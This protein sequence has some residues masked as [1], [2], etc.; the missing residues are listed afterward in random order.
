[1]IMDNTGIEEPTPEEDNIVLPPAPITRSA[2]V[3]ARRDVQELAAREAAF[4]GELAAYGNAA[5]LGGE[6]THSNDDV[7]ING[8][9]FGPPDDDEHP[10]H[11]LGGA[12]DEYEYEEWEYEP[13]APEPPEDSEDS[14]DE[15]DDLPSAAEIQRNLSNLRESH[16]YQLRPRAGGKVVTQAASQSG[17][18]LRARVSGK[19][20]EGRFVP[21]KQETS[22]HITVKKALAT[23]KR[24]AL[25]EIYREI[26]Q[27]DKKGVFHPRH[28]RTLPASS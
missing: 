12:Q 6:Q 7:I 23:H 13:H 21:D 24:K 19:Y 27:M 17:Y 9:N 26:M 2:A 11:R 14:A 25:I 18:N 15:D 28:P 16:R 10:Q 4:G 3:R 20:V 8:V 1:M 5:R 22:L